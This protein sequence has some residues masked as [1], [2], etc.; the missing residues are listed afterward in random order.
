[1]H[2]QVQ[3]RHRQ[4]NC[5]RDHVLGWWE[6][7]IILPR[8]SI[9]CKI[10]QYP[11]TIDANDEESWDATYINEVLDNMF[12]T[13]AGR[14]SDDIQLSLRTIIEKNRTVSRDSTSS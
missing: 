13:P 12:L 11:D 9:I 14:D 3:W 4:T 5:E 1:M 6:Y 10:R 2:D 7:T 8:R